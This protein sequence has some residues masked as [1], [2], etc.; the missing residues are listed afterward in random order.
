MKINKLLGINLNS[1]K[2]MTDK[3]IAKYL[4]AKLEL[5]IKKDTFTKMN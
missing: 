5:D 1:V 2:K 3:N 4:K